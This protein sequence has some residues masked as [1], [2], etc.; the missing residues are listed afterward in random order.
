MPIR[1]APLPPPTSTTLRNGLFESFA[2][3]QRDAG[4]VVIG[5]EHRRRDLVRKLKHARQRRE[6]AEGEIEGELAAV[7]NRLIVLRR[8]IDGMLWLAS[9]DH[10]VL[11]RLATERRVRDL[12]PEEV[13]ANLALA[14][15][16]NRSNPRELNFVSDL[17]SIVQIGDILRVRWDEQGTYLRLQEVKRGQ[18]NDK[19]SEMLTANAGVLSSRDLT[20]V[21]EQLGE[22]GEKQA[23]RMARQLSRFDRFNELAQADPADNLDDP[24]LKLLANTEPPPVPTY[25]HLLPEVASGARTN[26]VVF[27]CIDD[28]L[29]LIG[30]SESGLDQLRD[31]RELIHRLFHAKHADIKCQIGEIEELNRESPL[32]NL[33]AHNLMHVMSRAPLIWYPKELVLDLVMDRVRIYAQLDL[34]A[35]FRLAARERL[36]LSLIVGK[37]A[38]EGKRKKISGPMIENSKAYG[39][40]VG[41]LGGRTVNLRSSLFR[42]VYSD[43]VRPV[44]LLSLLTAMR[45]GLEDVQSK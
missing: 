23:E 1:I 28:C 6:L 22:A 37:E 17:T 26:G 11:G 25:L 14:T 5:L 33:V 38:E 12:Q 32:V 4:L 31:H 16:L 21:R 45:S 27:H 7:T 2:Q 40:K 8:F 15:R 43:L 44:G 19:L 20:E 10:S 42:S 9:P 13:E 34:V 36:S 30:L 29:W 41:F 3:A 24:D 35:F 39:V 18:V